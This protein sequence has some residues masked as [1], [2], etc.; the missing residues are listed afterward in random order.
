MEKKSLRSLLLLQR[1]LISGQR[2]AEVNG[3]AFCAQRNGLVTSAICTARLSASKTFASNLL[4]L[5]FA[6][7]KAINESGAAADV[8][9]GVQ[10]HFDVAVAGKRKIQVS[11]RALPL[12]R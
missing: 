8:V 4:I 5:L 7:A 3:V 10:G 6:P 2:C 11:T 12:L 9:A 1:R